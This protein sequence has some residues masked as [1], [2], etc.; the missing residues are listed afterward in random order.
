MRFMCDADT[1]I[2]LALLFKHLYLYLP[3][4]SSS[5]R[6]GTYYESTSNF[7]NMAH[8]FVIYVSNASAMAPNVVC[9]LDMCESLSLLRR[10]QV[11]WSLAQSGRL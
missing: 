8:A 1:T 6:L 9:R 7:D 11:R 2:S 10:R 3:P 4:L 5:F